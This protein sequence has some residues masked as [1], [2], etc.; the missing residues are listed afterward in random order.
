MK[1]ILKSLHT[2][3]S[4]GITGAVAAHLVLLTALPGLATVAEAAALRTG[5]AAVATWL[6]L[7][8][9]LLVLVSGLLAIAAQPAFGSA[10]W[11]WVKVA[12]GLVIFEGTLVSVQRPAERNLDYTLQAVAGKIDA[13][14][15]EA[16]L[17]SEWGALWVILA[18]CIA[19]IILGI[20]RPRLVR[21]RVA[22]KASQPVI[23]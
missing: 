15:L 2:V 19:N 17:H 11:V 9:L 6:L 22:A 21:R 7:P 5:I 18:V 13:A 1:K 12:L 4:V 16:M 3:G 8:S 14:E 23:D 10:G 20:W